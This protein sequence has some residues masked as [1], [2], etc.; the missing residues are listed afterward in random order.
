MEQYRK[1]FVHHR[2]S[3]LILLKKMNHEILKKEIGVISFGHRDHILNEINLLRDKIKD[4][5]LNHKDWNF[6]KDGLALY[7]NIED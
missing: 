1:N 2:I 6:E 5:K 4:Y 7:C 3:G